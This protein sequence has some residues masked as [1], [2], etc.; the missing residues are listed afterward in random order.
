MDRLQNT[1][2]EFGRGFSFVGR[3]VHFDV[4]GQDFYIDLLFYHLKLRCYVVID[5]QDGA[6][7]ARVRRPDEFLPLRHRRSP[8]AS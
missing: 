2:S 4:G 5:L 3:Q 7:Q 1:L 8:P 6:I